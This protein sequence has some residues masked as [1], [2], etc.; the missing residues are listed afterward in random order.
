MMVRLRQRGFSRFVLWGRSMGATSALL[1]SLA[2]RPQDVVLMVI[3]SPFYSFE[4]IAFE[5]ASK[6]VKAP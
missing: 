4:M 1:Y 3:D 5:I 2:Y 6:N